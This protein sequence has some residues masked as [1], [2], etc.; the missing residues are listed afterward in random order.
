MQSLK[1]INHLCSRVKENIIEVNLK[2]EMWKDVSWIYLTK[3]KQNNL[4][5]QSNTTIYIYFKL[6]LTETK[7]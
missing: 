4:W 3:R 7:D 5:F 1:E 2:E 6:C